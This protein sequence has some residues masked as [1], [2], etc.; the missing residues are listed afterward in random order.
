M[1]IESSKGFMNNRIS[2]TDAYV[3]LYFYCIVYSLLSF[4]SLSDAS[5]YN[6]IATIYT[7]SVGLFNLYAGIF[8]VYPLFKFLVFQFDCS[9]R[10]NH[11][12]TETQKQS[13]VDVRNRIRLN[14][15]FN[16][17]T[18]VF[19]GTLFLLMGCWPYFLHKST[20]ICLIC[21]VTAI[22]CIIPSIL[23]VLPRDK[24]A[25]VQVLAAPIP[26]AS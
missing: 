9:I 10:D 23:N 13:L 16:F 19:C 1:M 24:H 3:S 26:D 11:L 4:G 20:Y 5:H 14:G 17:S 2:R 8:R 12:L 22:L 21:T 7:I 6:I 18:C 25:T 15:I